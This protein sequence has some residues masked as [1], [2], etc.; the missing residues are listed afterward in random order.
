[1]KCVSYFFVFEDDV[2]ARLFVKRLAH[3]LRDVAILIS[4]N[5]VTVLDGRD[6]PQREE[7][8]RLARS[9]GASRVLVGNESDT[10]VPV[11]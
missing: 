11:R 5:S 8:L 9:S 4:A 2:T 6:P 3:Y 7:I 1:M 10:I